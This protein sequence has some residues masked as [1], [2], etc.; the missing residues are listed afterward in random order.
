MP[1][2]EVH[3]IGD[4]ARSVLVIEDFVPDLPALCADA[5]TKSYRQVQPFYPG[6]QSPID[7]EEVSEW[8][9]PFQPMLREAFGAEGDFQFV[10]AAYSLVTTPPSALAPIQRLPHVDGTDPLTLAVLVYLSGVDVG[11]TAFYRHKSTGYEWLDQT[12]FPQYEKALTADARQ[13]GI[14]GANYVTGDTPLFDQIAKFESQPGR[15]LIYSG[16][17]LHSG[18]IVETDKLTDDPRT[19]RLTLN[20]FF[21]AER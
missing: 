2:S 12:R 15:A 5:A 1:T 4:E 7:G 11:G 18:M 20:A 19:G 13:Y 17:S 16:T 8:I 9:A 3:V 10:N 14:P 21:K 6:I